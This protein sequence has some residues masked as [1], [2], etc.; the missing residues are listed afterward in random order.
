MTAYETLLAQARDH[1]QVPEA[2]TV[3]AVDQLLGAWGAIPFDVT[4]HLDSLTDEFV[5]C[6]LLAAGYTIV[7]PPLLQARASVVEHDNAEWPPQEADDFDFAPE[8]L[9]WNAI[10]NELAGLQRLIILIELAAADPA[11]VGNFRVHGFGQWVRESLWAATGVLPKDPGSPDESSALYRQA[12]ALQGR[13][14]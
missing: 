9:A 8:V 14:C 2:T 3:T 11:R 12:F 10:Q 6:S 4:P 5:D 1:Y 7:D 13:S